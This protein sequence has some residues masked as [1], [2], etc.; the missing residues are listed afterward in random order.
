MILSV[1]GWP[2]V[3]GVLALI[4][5]VIVLVVWLVRRLVLRRRRRG[6]EVAAV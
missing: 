3:L 2:T 1:Y 5:A 4:V 6:Q